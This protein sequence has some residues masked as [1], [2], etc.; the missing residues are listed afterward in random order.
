MSAYVLE[1][2]HIHRA[3]SACNARLHID[4]MSV[5]ASLFVLLH[6]NVWEIAC[7]QSFLLIIYK[8]DPRYSTLMDMESQDIVQESVGKV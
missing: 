5:L 6:V 1:A 4:M 3:M 8:L 7:Q 2:R